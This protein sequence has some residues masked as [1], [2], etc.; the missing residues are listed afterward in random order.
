M[1]AFEK[2]FALNPDMSAYLPQTDDLDQDVTRRL[3]DKV[4]SHAKL[5]METLEQ[6]QFTL[7]V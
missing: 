3:S 5:T 6:V 1:E 2:L 4:K 7:H